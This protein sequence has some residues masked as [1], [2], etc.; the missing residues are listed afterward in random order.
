MLD[1]ATSQR[2]HV[3]TTRQ[4]LDDVKARLTWATYGAWRCREP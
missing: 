3:A 1:Q 2:R 4:K